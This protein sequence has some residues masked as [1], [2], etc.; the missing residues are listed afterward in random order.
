MTKP[1]YE[2]NEQYIYQADIAKA[3]RSCGVKKG[4]VI[5][6]HSDISAFGKL[7]MLDAAFLLKSLLDS[8]KESVG[9]NGTIIMPTFTYSFTENKPYD[10]ANSKSKV[11]VLTEY[12]RK[13]PDVGRTAHAD[14]SVA[15]WGRRKD[16]LLKIGKDTFDNDSIF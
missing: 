7:S 14:H 8:L 6:V 1:L 4:D 11:G 13:Q 10:I 12:F 16:E 15:V 9:T 2:A 3:L 5:F